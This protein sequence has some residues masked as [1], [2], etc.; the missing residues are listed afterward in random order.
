M[1]KTLEKKIEKQHIM[2]Q[3]LR[4][5]LLPL[6]LPLPPPLLLQSSAHHVL[7]DVQFV[8]EPVNIQRRVNGPGQRR[9]VLQPQQLGQLQ[10]DGTQ[11]VHV[12]LA[13]PAAAAAAAAVAAVVEAMAVILAAV[14]MA[15][16]GVTVPACKQ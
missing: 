9:V 15:V 7:W 1:I 5:L 8:H 3:L 14:A 10:V 16:I 13:Q 2:L 12:D 11:L 6:P 4:L